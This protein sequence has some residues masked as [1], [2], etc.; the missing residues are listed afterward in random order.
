MN[1]RAV[2]AAM[3]LLSASRLSPAVLDN[4]TI[5]AWNDYIR[6]ARSE[7]MERIQAGGPFLWI[8]GIPNRRSEVRNGEVFVA[9]VG[10]NHPKRV[11]S[12]LIHDWIGAAFLPNATLEDTLAVISDYSR[13]KELYQPIIADSKLL[14][15]DGTEYKFSIIIVNRTLFSRTAFH[16][17][18]G[19]SYFQVDAKRW[20]SVGSSDT[21]WEIENYG[22][23]GE[24]ELPPNEG[25]GYIWRLYNLSRFEERDGGVYVER[26]VIV[27][28]RDIPAA[29]RWFI[30]P[31]VKRLSRNSLSTSLLQ[32]RNAVI[33]NKEASRQ[34]GASG[35]I[36]SHGPTE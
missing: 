13:Y 22:Q 25:S 34:T 23:P 30:E 24:R 27:L 26:E 9:P 31:I 17:E 33:W 32:T 19:D 2:L 10:S 15:W 7:M 3:V 8:D 28:S 21:V 1:I 36:P 29:F 5:A 12:G 35:M 16:S 11:A 6:E 4:R 14:G 18:C 20:Y